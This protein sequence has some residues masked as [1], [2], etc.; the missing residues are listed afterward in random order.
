MRR[1]YKRFYGLPQSA[2]IANSS[3]NNTTVTPATLVN[4]DLITAIDVEDDGLMPGVCDVRGSKF[5]ASEN[6]KTNGRDTLA[7]SRTISEV[8]ND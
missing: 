5:K 3:Q 1:L 8:S 7:S 4:G 2:R 6:D